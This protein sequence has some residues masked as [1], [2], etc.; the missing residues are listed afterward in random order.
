MGSADVVPGVSGGTIAFISGIYEELLTSIKSINLQ[1]LKVL[2]KEG[3]KPF[4]KHINGN[5]LV[6]L[7]TGISVAIV[8]LVRVVTFLLEQ[9]PVLL[10]GFFFGLILGSAI[11]VAR[12]VTKLDPVSVILVIAGGVAAY[13]ITRIT[14]TETTEDLWFVFLSGMIAIC[15]MILPGISGSFLLLMMGKYHFIMTSIKELNFR[16]I[17]VFGLGAA[18]GLL[19][20]SRVLAWLFKRFRNQTIGLLTGFMLGSLNKVWPWK[21]TTLFIPKHEGDPKEEWVAAVQE[22]VLPGDYV[23]TD[24]ELDFGVVE[25]AAYTPVVILLMLLG[26]GLVV[27]LEVINTR[28]QRTAVQAKLEHPT[29]E[30]TPAE[31]EA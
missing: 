8:S 21:V 27:G 25:K 15:A 9:Y 3:V 10:W 31:P 2:F 7:F 16:V 28:R 5:F 18:L 29:E 17:I 22:N 13:F 23:V 11:V 19:G 14:P 4:W 12:S 24:L 30:E 1:A 6:A 20:F 26:F